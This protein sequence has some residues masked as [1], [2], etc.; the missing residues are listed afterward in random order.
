MSKNIQVDDY[1]NRLGDEQKKLALKLRAIIFKTFPDIKE[2]FKWSLPYYMPVCYIGAFKDHV[3]LGILFGGLIKDAKLQEMM[4]GTGALMRHVKIYK[5]SDIDQSKISRILKEA[6][7][8]YLQ[9]QVDKAD[10]KR[11]KL[12][13]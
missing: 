4:E 5:M 9:G 12:A 2:E 1:I 10:A 13:S 7:K 11:I 6:Y 3:N 8:Q